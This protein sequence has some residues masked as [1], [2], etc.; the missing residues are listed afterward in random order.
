M[1]EAPKGAQITSKLHSTLGTLIFS[2]SH[3]MTMM[4]TVYQCCDQIT[5]TQKT[6]YF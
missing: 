2:A 5:K 3:L 6:P 1:E 4:M